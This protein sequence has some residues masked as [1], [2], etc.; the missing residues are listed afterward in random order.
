LLHRSRSA[1][2]AIVWRYSLEAAFDFLRTHG[3]EEIEQCCERSYSK[4]GSDFLTRG[5]DGNCIDLVEASTHLFDGADNQ[6]VSWLGLGC[7]DGMDGKLEHAG[8][9]G[10]YGRDTEAGKV[11]D[12]VDD[13]MFFVHVDEIQWEEDAKSMNSARG[14]DPES[15]I[16]PE[17]EL[18]DKTFET[19]EGC[20]GRKDA[21]AKEA[22]PRLVIYA[23]GSFLH[24]SISMTGLMGIRR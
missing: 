15:F 24:L 9:L 6:L 21:E 7:I 1:S 3:L 16:D 20:I 10:F 8:S 2:G 17:P 5:V 23:I 14:K 18:A 12:D 11:L 19:R 4:S 22:F 13:V